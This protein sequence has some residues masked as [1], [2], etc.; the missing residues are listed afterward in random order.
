MKRCP[1]CDLEDTRGLLCIPCC[2]AWT[3]AQVKDAGSILGAMSWAA[4]RA[5]AFERKK[6]GGK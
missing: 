1:I 5:R 3:R 4:K 2:R 6:R